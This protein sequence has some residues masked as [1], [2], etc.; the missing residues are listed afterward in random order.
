[1]RSWEPS[2]RPRLAAD[3]SGNVMLE[4]AL[5]LP[6]LLLLAVGLFDLGSYSVQ[7]SAMLQG[8]QAGAQ[9]GILAYAESDNIN[10]TARTATGLTGVTATNLVFC[11]CVSGTQITCG[12]T[13]SGGTTA[14]R[15]VTVTTNK[16]YASVLTATTHNF[17]GFG[18]WTPPTTVSGSVTMMVVVP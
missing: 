15:Y 10:S 17:A 1:M 11:E 3:R 9:Y 12:T 6:V 7:K 18:T 8:A 14:R 5:G 2:D 4:F 13:C 16:T